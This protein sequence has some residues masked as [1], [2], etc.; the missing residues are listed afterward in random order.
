[1]GACDAIV[2]GMVRHRSLPGLFSRLLVALGPLRPIR[3]HAIHNAIILLAEV[4]ARSARVLGL[5]EDIALARFEARR[6]IACDG[7]PVG[8]LPD[9]AIH[10]TIDL[11]S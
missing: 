5:H 9:L 11:L 8:P 1:M 6:K 3:H 2:E 7:V 4:W 10:D